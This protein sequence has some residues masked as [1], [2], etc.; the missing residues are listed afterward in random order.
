MTYWVIDTKPLNAKPVLLTIKGEKNNFVVRGCWIGKHTIEKSE[1][2]YFS[3]YN[4]DDDTY[5]TPEGWYELI[6]FMENLSY[7]KIYMDEMAWYRKIYMDVIAWAEIPKPLDK[8]MK[9][10]L[11][12]FDKIQEYIKKLNKAPLEDIVFVYDGLEYAAEEHDIE[13]WKS[14]GQSNREYARQLLEQIKASKE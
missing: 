13:E 10:S 6:S 2:S 9:I 12:D 1:D 8:K 11:H 5:Y 14:T 3:D 4:E 7:R